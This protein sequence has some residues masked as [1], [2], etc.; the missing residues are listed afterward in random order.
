MAFTLPGLYE[1]G[2]VHVY[3][4]P[5][6]VPVDT[7]NV[8][9]AQIGVVVTVGVAG[10]AFIVMV[11]VA[12]PEQPLLS[13]TV[14]VAVYVPAGALELN[15]GLAILVLLKCVAALPVQ[16]TVLNVPGTEILIAVPA[17]SVKLGVAV[18]KGV[19]LSVIVTTKS[20]RGFH[21]H[22]PFCDT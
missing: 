22:L 12:L 7:L 13:V 2:V 6:T 11:C 15:I 10:I 16:A 14:M 1:S 4:A 8:F 18:I 20:E 9:P 21:N 19:G 5:A 17:H 3:V